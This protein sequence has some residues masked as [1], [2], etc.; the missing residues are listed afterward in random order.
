MNVRRG[1]ESLANL[2]LPVT[3]QR[4]RKRR[5]RERLPHKEEEK[6]S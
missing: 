3:K 5:V 2:R 6:K 4:K 1:R